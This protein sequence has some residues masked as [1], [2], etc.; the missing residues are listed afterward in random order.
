MNKKSLSV[1]ASFIIII[2]AYFGYNLKIDNISD[3]GNIFEYLFS[4]NEYTE[5]DGDFLEVNFLDVGQGDCSVSVLPSGEI[6]MIDAGDNG[7]ESKIFDFLNDRGIDKID[8]LIATHPH[9]DHIGGIPEIITKYEVS[10]FYMPDVVHTSATFEKM[11]EL[12]NQNNI[13]VHSASSEKSVINNSEI[14]VE[15]V[16]P[17]GKKYE[18]LNDYSAV[19]RMEYKDKSFLFCADMEEL[20]ENEVLESGIVIDSDVLKVAHHGSSTSS[21]VKF[22]EEVSPEISVISCGRNNDYNHPHVEIL[23]RITDIS[24]TV[25]R[26]DI[27]GHIRITTDGSKL[28]YD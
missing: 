13:R 7:N 16:A 9:S 27:D 3:V 1:I 19:V 20:S 2:F 28:I 6:L 17:V 25:Y 4:E 5:F 11:I 10:E 12:L 24:K 18:E 26:T 21:S 15:F 14:T 22:L 23:K 8:Y